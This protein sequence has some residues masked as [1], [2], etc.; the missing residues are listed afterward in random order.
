LGQQLH[1]HDFAYAALQP[2][3]IHGAVA[4]AWDDDTN[5]ARPKRG[6]ELTDVEVPTPN[7]LPLSNDGFNLGL[8]RQAML[9]RKSAISLS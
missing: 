9:P 6:S 1:S 5:P 7:S 2:V 8:A 3:S 4:V